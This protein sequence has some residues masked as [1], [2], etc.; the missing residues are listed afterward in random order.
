MAGAPNRQTA[1]VFDQGQKQNQSQQSEDPQPAVNLPQ[2]TERERSKVA[3]G[4]Y[5]PIPEEILVE[6]D[7]PARPFKKK[8]RQFFTTTIV[9]AILV[10]LILFFAGQVLPVAVVI[11]AVFLIY[12]TAVIPP[13][14]VHIKLSNYGLYIG[15]EAFAW[16]EMGRFWFD[17]KN[18]QEVLQ[19]ELFRF[20]GRL[21]LVIIDEQ[22]PSKLDFNLV[23]TEV[24]IKEKPELTYFER[25]AQW[26]QEKI[27]LD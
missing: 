23:L 8:N 18:G 22:T 19:I 13:S 10:S 11:S 14:N 20:P 7:A 6:W 2:Q 21:T 26:I 3:P 5:R 17:K 27:P 15:K 9:I 16:Q 12:V 1:Q 24:L 4:L 25:A